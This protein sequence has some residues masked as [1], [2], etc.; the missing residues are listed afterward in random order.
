MLAPA[1]SIMHTISGGP[2]AMHT[3]R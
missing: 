3:C 2:T 1:G